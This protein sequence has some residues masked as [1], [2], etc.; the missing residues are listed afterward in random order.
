MVAGVT[1]SIDGHTAAISVEAAT[2]EH[3]GNWIFYVV[4]D[5]DGFQYG[6]VIT[7]DELVTDVRLPTAVLPLHYQV[8]LIPD[9]EATEGS[10]IR[11]DGNVEMFVE[12]VAETPIFTF[13]MDELTP[14]T[15]WMQ[16][17]DLPA[18]VQKQEADGSI[19]NVTVSR[20][21]FDFQRTFVHLELEEGWEVGARY[22]V[23]F[24]FY[25][26]ITR[27]GFYT[28][29]FYPQVCS[30]TNGE[31]KMCWF[32]QGESTTIRYRDIYRVI[33]NSWVFID[34]SESH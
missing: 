17:D 1:G 28:Y 11:Y 12:V 16:E 29:G 33:N 25:A 7:T 22:A 20:V 34:A 19:L 32:T 2:E 15:E 27:G 26:D 23:R 21:T 8:R 3:L 31:D 30:E 13:H 4:S 6:L 9:F 14:D 5:I 18:M 10:N 24:F